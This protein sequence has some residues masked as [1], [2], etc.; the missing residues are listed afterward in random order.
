MSY[1]PSPWLS[2]PD[3]SV[4]PVGGVGPVASVGPLAPPVGSV[5]G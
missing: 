4:G 2:A 5:G 3:A 1:L